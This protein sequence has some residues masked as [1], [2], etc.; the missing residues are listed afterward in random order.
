MQRFDPAMA[1]IAF[2]FLV[3]GLVFGAWATNIPH[4]KAE[5]A[6]GEA[7]VGTVLLAV[8]AG[9][10]AFMTLCGIATRHFGS[11]GLS[12]LSALLFAAA[13]PLVFL[14]G[15]LPALYA[16]AVLL[17]A[18]TGAMDVTMNQQASLLEQQRGR[19]VM[20]GLHG[21][22][23]IGALGGALLTYGAGLAGLSP[24][25]E[26]FWLLA[27]IAG[28]AV[29]LFP[30]LLADHPEPRQVQDGP[31]RG[32]MFGHAALWV[33]GI[34]S[35]LTMMSEG[36]IAD[37]STLYVLEYSDAPAAQA[38]LGFAAYSA[39]MI[40]A[41]LC[42]DWMVIRLGARTVVLLSGT[43]VAAGMALALSTSVFTVQLTGLAVT[44]FGIANLIPVIFS[45]AARL[46]GLPK[47]AGIT[48]VSVAGYSGFLI[49]PV[50]ISGAAELWGLDRALLVI[51]L[52]GLV[53][54][55]AAR[56]FPSRRPKPVVP[57]K[58]GRP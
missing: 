37:W 16:A 22:F 47:G 21:G 24:L 49:G 4:I 48:F 32:G 15:S 29:L 9:A 56:R 50:L 25:A 58:A 6:L 35:F 27:A 39:L 42:G 23:S 17:G 18:G 30:H 1:A 11:R 10:V 8:A 36:G 52:I 26:A 3:N 14:A 41:R 13:L 45:D 54:A 55:A 7:E 2:L 44:G 57:L 12:M 51:V 20:S 53:L 19:A 40:T 5:F 43:L 46:P 38:P 33:L 28:A 31:R 34:L